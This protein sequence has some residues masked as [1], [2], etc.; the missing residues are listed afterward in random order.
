MLA[1]GSL[2][3]E[4][5]GLD[6]HG[7]TVTLSGSLAAGRLVLYFYPRDFT[8]VCTA[9]A[10]AFRDSTPEFASLA[11]QVVGVSRDD[12]DSHRR[13]AAQHR[14]PYP[15]LADVD[16]AISRAYEADRWLVSLVKR[17]TYV[18]ATDRK[19]LGAFRHELSAEK[20]LSDVRAVLGRAS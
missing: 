4:F 18:I 1:V 12:Q 7:N 17:I 6:Q 16:G 20:H 5:S 11:A 2:A 13:F 3:P 9:Q 10:C 15:L 19:I 8:S 14:V